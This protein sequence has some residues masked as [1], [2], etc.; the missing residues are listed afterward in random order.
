MVAAATLFAVSLFLAGVLGLAAHRASICTVKAVAE[1]VTTRRA[2]MLAG[3]GKTILWILLVT[4]ALTPLLPAAG[5]HGWKLSVYTLAGGAIF[6]MGA[7]I[8]GGCA[9]ST[10]TRLAQGRLAMVFTLAGFCVGL[11]GHA[12]L[13]SQRV[14]PV[15]EPTETLLH[16][17]APW[18]LGLL[19]VLA[20]WAARELFALWRKRPT[21]RS[22]AAAIFVDRYRLS[23]A[24]LIMGASNAVLYLAYGNWAYTSV[25]G[26][27]V[28]QAL[29]AG[30]H[31][32]A[33]SWALAG[34]LLVGMFLSAWLARRFRLDWRPSRNWLFS[35]MGGLLMGLG[36]AMVP[37]GNDVLLLNGIPSLSLHAVLAYLAMI[38]GIVLTLA[39]VRFAGGKIDAVD[40]SGD[41]CASV[42]SRHRSA[43]I[44]ATAAGG[45]GR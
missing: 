39:V 4:L 36:A 15:P 25:L 27:G 2:Y 21:D 28:G 11:A 5:N 18:R 3:F 24:A 34:A 10:L 19:L 31:V 13:A 9:F 44:R 12:M 32:A 43:P 38:G 29:G 14:V 41:I 6:G 26:R 17:P 45:G 35:L 30:E 8:N 33:I 42:E 22:I 20:L 16:L 1:I 40:C 23:T 37:G 7:V